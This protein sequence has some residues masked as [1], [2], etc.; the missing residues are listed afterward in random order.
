MNSDIE[1]IDYGA[2]YEIGINLFIYSK[3]IKNS[4]NKIDSYIKSLND[5]KV[6]KGQGRDSLVNHYLNERNNLN[7]LY[8]KLVNYS[9]SIL[10]VFEYSLAET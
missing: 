1:H 5:D 8:L 7:L 3:D 10:E 6:W 2:L 4:L 9:K